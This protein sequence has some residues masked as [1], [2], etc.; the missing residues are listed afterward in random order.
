M[1][2]TSPCRTHTLIIAGIALAACPLL[3]PVARADSV[4]QRSTGKT[5]R[6]TIIAESPEGIRIETSAGTID[7][8]VPDIEA[9]T[10]EGAAGAM[11]HMAEG[12]ERAGQLAKA[13][14]RYES[15][16]G[17][18]KRGTF[19]RTAAEFALARMRAKEALE[20][21]LRR[22]DDAIAA[23]KEFRQG[24]PGSRFHYELHELLAQLLT[25]K[26]DYEAARAAY[27]EPVKAPWPEY[28]LQWAL[29]AYL[30]RLT[31]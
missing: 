22:V 31:S 10:Y 12:I 6:G 13:T 18:T 19:V 11:L 29:A 8:P 28:E 17:M 23:L 7:V 16:I 14:R 3:C 21:N 9:V 2:A 25:A 1:P 4:K 5:I 30:K 20:G 15:I 27:Q 26:G 24:H